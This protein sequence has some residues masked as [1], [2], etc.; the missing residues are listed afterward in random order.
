MSQLLVDRL[1]SDLAKRKSHANLR[2]LSRFSEQNQKIDFSS[3]D[4]LGLSANR[5]FQKQLKELIISSKHNHIGSTGSRLISGNHDLFFELE[6]QIA[7]YHQS[8]AGLIFNSGYDA[9][10]GLFSAL[11]NKDTIFIYDELCHASIRDGI[12]LSFAKA[13]HFTHN[14][15]LDL[16]K[17]INQAKT[18]DKNIIIAVEALYSMDGDF[19]PLV[20]ICS[21][22][23]KYAAQVIVDEAHSSG[24]YGKFGQGRVCELSLEKKVFARVNTFGKALGTHGAIVLGSELLKNYLINFSRSFIYTTALSSHSLLA[25]KLAYQFLP[26]LENERQHLKDLSKYLNVECKKH[27][28]ENYLSSNSQIHSLLIAGNQRVK[29]MASYLNEFGFNAPAILSP[30]VAQGQ[31]RLRICLHA[32][33]DCGQVDRLILQLQILI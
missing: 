26:N 6:E 5:D 12:R 24:V 23:D 18:F 22:A 27:F 29:S 19:A 8:S 14:D 3:L 7:K 20:E 2:V 21:L 33:N 9:N 11:G 32:F 17:K 4:Y 10:L 30:T 13:W 31:E 28:A 15:L 16:E 1:E 25:I